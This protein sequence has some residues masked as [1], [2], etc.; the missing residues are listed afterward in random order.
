MVLF[1]ISFRLLFVFGVRLVNEPAVACLNENS[2][3]D[4]LSPSKTIAPISQL[5][6]PDSG[7]RNPLMLTSIAGSPPFITAEPSNTVRFRG[8]SVGLEYTITMVHPA[9]EFEIP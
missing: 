1:H 4:T 7:V 6:G 2:S 8:T 5:T 3:V 9:E